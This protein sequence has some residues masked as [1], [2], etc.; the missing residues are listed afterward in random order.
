M[1]NLFKFE[2]FYVGLRIWTIISFFS[3]MVGL[4]IYLR[5][6]K[7]KTNKKRVLGKILF[8]Q[9]WVSVIFLGLINTIFKSRAKA[10]LFRKINLVQGNIRSCGIELD[11]NKS[12]EYKNLL[13]SI[14]EIARHHSTPTYCGNVEFIVKSEKVDLRFERDNSIKTEYWIYWDKYIVTKENPIGYLRT[15]KLNDMNCR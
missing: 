4:V 2:D 11:Q 7:G 1:D 14:G 5:L 3:G 10:E 9:M 12:Q 6:K 13:F 8:G 15:D